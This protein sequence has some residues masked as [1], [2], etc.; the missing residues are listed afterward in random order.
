MRKFISRFIFALTLF[1]GTTSLMAENPLWIRYPAI[2]PDGTTIVF[3]YQGDLFTVPSSGGTAIP[4][5]IHQAY[6]Y[7]PVWSPDGKFIAFASVRYGNFDVF[8]IPATGGKARRLTDFSGSEFPVCFTPDGKNVLY[9]AAIQDIPENSMYPTG[10]LSELYSV[11]VEGGRP[12]QLLPTPAELARVSKDGNFILFQD[13]KG[14]EDNWRKHHTSSVTRDIWLHDKSKGSFKMLSDFAGEDLNPVFSNDEKEVYF[15]SEKSGSMNVWKM[16]LSNPANQIQ[17]T[18]FSKNPVRFLSV[19]ANNRLCFGF[20]GEIYTKDSGREPQ[21][22][23]IN[24][25]VD[26]KMNPVD[27]EKK[28]SGATEMAV[29]P[30]GK[31]IAFVLRGDV[32]VTSADFPTTRRIT[33]TP[34][35]ERSVSFSPDGKKILYASERDGS[36]NLYQSS[37]ANEKDPN[38]SRA[39]LL[40]EEVVVATE[41]EEFFPKY[42]PDGKEVAY[43]ED[44][45]TLMVINLETKATRK[46]LDEQYNYSYSD[47][48]QWY[49]WSPDGKWFLVDY[50][51][52]VVFMN[53]IG[54]ISADGS[55]EVKNLTMSGYNNNTAKWMMAGKMMLY[56]S[57]REGLRSHGSWGSQYDVYAMF[58]DPDAWE[59]FKMSEEEK[60]LLDEDEKDKNKDTKK[61]EDEK[62]KDKKKKKDEKDGVKK[63][64]LKPVKIV[65][66]G[67]ED[68]KTRLTINS[69]SLSDAI[70][71]PDG[72]KLYYL[73]RFEKGYDLWVKDLVKNETKLVHKLEGGGGAMQMDKEGKTLFMISGGQFI[74][75]TVAD[76]KKETIG[77]NAEFVLN[78][79]GEREYMFEH[80][81][82][83]VRE[84][85]Y[86]PGL[87]GVDWD[88]YKKEYQKFLPNITNNFDFAEMLSE[89]L[90]E[91]NASHTGSGYRY[92]DENGDETASLGVFFDWKYSGNGLKVLEVIKKGPLDKPDSKVKPGVI[93]EKIDGD[94]IPANQSWFGMLNHKNGKPTLLSLY[95]PENGERWD[96]TIKP[97]SYGAANQLLYERWVKS[98]REAVEKLSNGRLG[99]VHVRGMDSPSFR[100][101]Y[102]EI[103]GRNH[104]KE[105]VIVDTRFNG[106]GWLHNDLAILLSGKKYVELWPNGKYFGFEPQN[107]WTKP[108][109]VL[110][111]ESNYSDAHFFPYTYTTLKIGKTVGMP[112]AGTATA[113]WWE[114][115]QDPTLYFGIPQVGTKDANGNYLENQQLEPDVKQANDYDIVITG[116]DQQ[117]EKAVESLLKELDEKK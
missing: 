39:T 86:D 44:R 78:L 63:D 96:E 92:S 53:D 79:P 84:K 6:D 54:L 12:Q 90:G 17:V 2:S 58:F 81:W 48:D 43:L 24:L 69:S 41:K 76:D 85:F 66:E 93:I 95:N 73:S 74:K 30:N 100:E 111:N 68:R 9:T 104:E 99:Y 52:N 75:V 80:I 8:L 59:K 33:E 23:A 55:G 97:I 61:D 70:V 82:R 109:V 37:L 5:T 38:F 65:F 25:S 113:V 88:Y 110:M 28:N 21:K 87:H 45:E 46:I 64:T 26:E 11:P 16:P 62:E 36:W 40:K 27:F 51:P 101:T 13:R 57:D 1:V 77:Y 60:K 94:V 91:L 34:E 102:S 115:L 116:R 7:R 19:G 14:Y 15:L 20:D 67:L 114:T 71:T 10:M 47:G 18:N 117:L 22:V 72:K 106:G 42:S 98:R 103:L 108:S 31:E 50:S 35:Q 107:Q 29:S 4:L 3:S 105:A 89:M 83:Q 32:F 56:F 112:V 49:D